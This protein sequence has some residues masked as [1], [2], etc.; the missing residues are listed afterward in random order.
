MAGFL[1]SHLFLGIK[2]AFLRVG[3][4]KIPEEKLESWR[5]KKIQYKA[6][7]EVG[8]VLNPAVCLSLWKTGAV[9]CP[10]PLSASRI[11]VWL[12]WTQDRNSHSWP[13]LG[14]LTSFTS[15]TVCSIQ[16]WICWAA[17]SV[18]KSSRTSQRSQTLAQVSWAGRNLHLWFFR[19]C[20]VASKVIPEDGKKRDWWEMIIPRVSKVGI[21]WMGWM[22]LWG[23]SREGEGRFGWRIIPK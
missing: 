19:S 6:A 13:D 4:K 7:T 20:V 12:C 5:E 18:P 11:S 2:D 3:E 10:G 9:R 17:L 23:G 14:M 21:S 15:V 8:Q 22:Q 16:I 1:F